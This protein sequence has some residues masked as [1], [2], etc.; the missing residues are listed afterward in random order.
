[1]YPLIVAG[2]AHVV[3]LAH[4][5]AGLPMRDMMLN[6]LE[7][8]TQ[9]IAR[10]VARFLPRLLVMLLIVLVGWLIAYLLRAALR[11]VLRLSRFD[12]LSEHAGASQLLKKAD[13]PASSELLSRFVFWV[14][15]L[16][17][18]LVGISVLGI[19]GFQE[20]ISNFFGF[21]PRL[22]A[23]LV[24]FFFGLMAA[25]FFSRSALLAAVNADL[26]SPRLISS[27]VRVLIVILVASMTFEELGLAEH[28]VLVA[29]A[30]VFG[31]LMFGLALAFGLG[32]RDLAR[33]FLERRF[34][35]GKSSEEQREDELSP[36]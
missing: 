35:H 6:E 33:R 18:I 15:W 21:L 31:S 9:E 20:H 23:A 22:V 2:Y 19:V 12:R 29:F 13:L 34:A 11:S 28:T 10:S 24:V 5:T 7:Q 8:A 17:F 14:V 30:I 26:P 25:S 27:T 16:G 36:L 3:R 4:G 32:G 1:M